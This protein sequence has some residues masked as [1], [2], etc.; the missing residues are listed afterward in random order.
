MALS[1]NG[2]SLMYCLFVLSTTTGVGAFLFDTDACSS[3]FTE[4]RD[5]INLAHVE[6]CLSID[7]VFTKLKLLGDRDQYCLS[8]VLNQ[9]GDR[10]GVSVTIP[11]DCQCNGTNSLMNYQYSVQDGVDDRKRQC[12]YY[13]PNYKAL[14]DQ[15]FVDNGNRAPACRSH[16]SL[17]FHLSRIKDFSCLKDLIYHLKYSFDQHPSPCVCKQSL[18]YGDPNNCQ[19]FHSYQALMKL[20]ES[21]LCTSKNSQWD[22]LHDLEIRSPDCRKKITSDLAMHFH[23]TLPMDPC[24]CHPAKN[25]SNYEPRLEEGLFQDCTNAPGSSYSN[26]RKELF[27]GAKEAGCSTHFHLW[28]QLLDI[29]P[30]ESYDCTMDL[31][32]RSA[33][34]Y[35]SAELDPCKCTGTLP[36]TSTSTTTR[37]SPSTTTTS[38]SSA[39]TSTTTTTSSAP[40]SPHR[41]QC[42]K[43]DLIADIATA[44]YVHSNYSTPCESKISGTNEDLVLTLCNIT[45]VEMWSRGLQVNSYCNSIPSYSPISTFSVRGSYQPADAQSGVFLECI[46]EGF[47]MVIQPCNGVPQ[48]IHVETTGVFNNNANNYYTVV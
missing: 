19:Q 36:I 25:I 7:K 6:N 21:N 14:F 30:F 38:T 4:Y 34:K 3:R 35:P 42:R 39:T 40:F 12:L 10:Y 9:L 24:S 46:P 22:L 1:I 47:K 31:I 48:I 16:H 20:K 13:Q 44:K 15:F 33:N 8:H 27:Y 29:R 43:Y 37:T 11:E 5:L 28:Q 41:F 32:L 18:Q 26:L 2:H 17:W 45:S 23:N